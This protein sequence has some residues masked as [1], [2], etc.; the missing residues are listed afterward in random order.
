MK[1][2]SIRV[3]LTIK[4]ITCETHGK[5]KNHSKLPRY[6]GVNLKP[7]PTLIGNSYTLV[8]LHMAAMLFEWLEFLSRHH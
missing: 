5:N 4:L 7:G 1:I 2:S 3:E 6:I 8:V